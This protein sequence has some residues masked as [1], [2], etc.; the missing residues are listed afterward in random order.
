M[1]LQYVPDDHRYLQM[2]ASIRRRQ[3]PAQG[4]AAAYG[5]SDALG[6]RDFVQLGA[7]ESSRP[8]GA[9]AGPRATDQIDTLAREQLASAYRPLSFDLQAAMRERLHALYERHGLEPP[10]SL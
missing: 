5:R 7:G 10:T 2:L 8:G 1:K 3:Q 4:P 6:Y 9:W